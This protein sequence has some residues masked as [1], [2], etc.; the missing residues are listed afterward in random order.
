MTIRAVGIDPGGTT[1]LICIDLPDD[2]DYAK[3]RYV[4]SATITATKTQELTAPLQQ[5]SIYQRVSTHLLTLSP[6]LIVLEKPED[7]LPNWVGKGQ[8]K[9]GQS[10][11]ALFGLGTHY[12]LAL[13]ACVRLVGMPSDCRVVAYPVTSRQP[14]PIKRKGVVVGQRVFSLGWMQRRQSRPPKREHVLMALA[15]EYRALRSRPFDGI[16]RAK[17][18]T[19]ELPPEHVLMALGVLLFHCDR[20]RG[21]V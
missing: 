6:R 17:A 1:G 11:E 19:P 4:G 13:A 3:A 21:K 12:G 14:K 9:R 5:G 15:N 10:R 2:L 16:L 18:S 20:E 8:N 7:A